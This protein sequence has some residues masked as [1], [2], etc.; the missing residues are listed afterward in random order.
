MCGIIGCSWQDRKLINLGLKKLVHR[1]PDAQGKYIDSKVSLGHRRLSI[2][3]L[4]SKGKQPMSNEN[5]DVWIV[6]NGEIYN[7]KK[8]RKDLKERHD[9]KS[10]SDTEVLIHLYEEKGVGMLEDLQGAFAFC[11]YDSKKGKMFLARDRV[12]IKPLYYSKVG[13]GL[14][15][16]SEIKG[17]LEHY[18]IDRKVS[19]KALQ[20]YLV[21]RANCEEESMFKN[22]MKLMPGNFIVY[23]LK[24]KKLEKRKY[25]DLKDK[26]VEGSY[27]D[28]L[29]GVRE[30]L[31]TSVKERLM[32]DVPYGAYLSGGVDSGAIISL[33]NRHAQGKVKTFSVGFEE[34]GADSE[35]NAAGELSS[36]LGTDHHE[37][38]IGRKSVKHLPNIIK[39]TDEPFADPTAIPTYLLSEY[40]K[41][42]GV[43]VVLTGEGAD[44][45]FAG[46]PQYKF[47][48]GHDIG[49]KRIP[50]GVRKTLPLVLSKMPPWILDKGFKFASK[51]GEK[52]IERFG[53][54]LLS[55]KPEEQYFEQVSIF[56]S[57][58]QKELI[59]NEFDYSKYGKGFKEGVVSGSQKLEFKNQMVDDLLMKVDKNTMAFGVEGRV[60]FL[61]H[62]L[63]ELAFRMPDK[64]K[65][66]GLSNDKFILR[67]AVKDLV[68][69]NTGSR[70]KRHFFVPIDSWLEDE[71]G[72]LSKDLLDAAY[73]KKQSI[74]N[75]SYVDKIRKGFDKSRL[76]YSRQLW[77]LLSF[78]IWH[79]EYIEGEKVK[80]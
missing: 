39:N 43:S 65:L 3:D 69:K 41:K 8:L 5:G 68:P 36:E 66:N 59:G 15:F 19:K 26:V 28:Y 38:V 56:N 72:S 64:F 76:F 80:V 17:L 27:G 52:G 1:G 21:F 23:D 71:L 62:R 44:E 73:L 35:L 42:K 74:F 49:F 70:K 55:D 46:Y 53:N 34:E 18:E 12:G 10:D 45:L 32:G 60:P 37:L 50:K 29:Q 61:D 48:K 11:I 58:E 57:K 77:S 40:T 79:K 31:E 4:S 20:S 63:V 14:I 25:W 51:L 78:Q 16:S 13:R 9:F 54:Y 6:F 47:M 33:M 2:L 22:I 75:P 7:Y 30:L 24:S 67:D